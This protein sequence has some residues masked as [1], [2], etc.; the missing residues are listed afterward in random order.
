M[1]FLEWKD[2]G[3]QRCYK[4]QEHVHVI[5]FF[6]ILISHPCLSFEWWDVLFGH[7]RQTDE[8]WILFGAIFFIPVVSRKTA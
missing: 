4:L 6:N 5:F 8:G 1:D 7:V 2:A 3:W